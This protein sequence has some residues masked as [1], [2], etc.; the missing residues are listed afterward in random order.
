MRDGGRKERGHQTYSRLC[1]WNK[2]EAIP[3]CVCV[4]AREGTH[5]HTHTNT[6]PRK[7]LKINGLRLPSLGWCWAL[8]AGTCLAAKP[9][10]KMPCHIITHGVEEMIRPA[11][12]YT[13]L[14]PSVGH[15]V[16]LSVDSMSA[17]DVSR[18]A[19][20]RESDDKLRETNRNCVG[21]WNKLI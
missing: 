14:F 2:T 13:G 16:C 15:F 12:Q 18:D 9:P 4:C 11:P 3:L 7:Q 20:T 6:S 8:L 10:A 5:T 19:S 17:W 1:R 21:G